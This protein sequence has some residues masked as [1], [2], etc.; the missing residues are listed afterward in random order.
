MM[1]TSPAGRALIEK[2]E[3]LRLTA[4]R[5]TGGIWTI[6]YGHTN[7]VTPGMS[8]NQ[9]QADQFLKED[10]ASAAACVNLHCDAQ[11]TQNQFDALVSFAFNIGNGAFASSTLLR[12]LNAD[13]YT[14]AAGQFGRWVHDASGNVEPGL[15]TRRADERALFEKPL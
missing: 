4:Y 12:L 13:D 8:I 2:F 1:Q 7:G 3:G 6:G 15:V 9:P 11:L 10:L 5:D 14:G